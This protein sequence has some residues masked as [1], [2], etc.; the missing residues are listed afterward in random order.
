MPGTGF[1]IGLSL[2]PISP[3]IFRGVLGLILA[4]S[5]FH[6]KDAP[7]ARPFIAMLLAAPL[8]SLGY[9]FELLSQEFNST[10][11]WARIQFIGIAILPLTWHLFAIQHLS[12]R[13]WSLR[14]KKYRLMTVLI[15]IITILLVWTNEAHKLVWT[16]TGLPTIGPFQI[17]YVEYSPWFWVFIVYVYSLILIASVRL[18]EGLAR[19]VRSLG[20][21][22]I[23]QMATSIG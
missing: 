4:F 17:M 9:A 15:P 1:E 3:L 10:F 11:F 19:T 8:W 12:K 16:Q 23:H 6:N 2:F 21:I 14:S 22:H 7:G 5:V 13:K 18:I 20:L